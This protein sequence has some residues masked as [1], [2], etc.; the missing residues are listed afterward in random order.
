MVAS[1]APFGTGVGWAFKKELHT[2]AH[3]C[4]HLTWDTTLPATRGLT[5]SCASRY[6]L[7]SH[8]LTK[9]RQRTG[10]GTQVWRHKDVASS[11][12]KLCFFARLPAAS[13]LPMRSSRPTKKPPSIPSR[14]HQDPPEMHPRSPKNC[15][16][17]T[18]K[19]LAR[20]GLSGSPPP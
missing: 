8:G 10:L 13:P 1:S 17:I 7:E 3:P 20:K 11:T 5:K 15:P 6:K 12:G 14:S 9:A 16:S 4:L 18:C 2:R 19:D